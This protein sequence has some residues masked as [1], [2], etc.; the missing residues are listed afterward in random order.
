MIEPELKKKLLERMFAS[1][2]YIE[3]FVGYLDKAVEGLHESLEWFENNPPQDVDWESWHIADTPEG[4]R[5]KAVPNFERMLRSARQGLENAKKGDYQV[6]E[7]LT[8]SMMGLTRDMDVLGGK[9]WDYVPKELDDKFFNNLY[10]ARK[11][12]SNI[13]RTVG[14]YWKTP[15]SILKENITGPIDEQELLKYLEP[16]ERP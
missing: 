13:W 3:Q 15:E 4:W 6:I 10:K 14:D 1:P 5:I 11:M 9:W 2:E 7:G 16:H 8:G 12:A